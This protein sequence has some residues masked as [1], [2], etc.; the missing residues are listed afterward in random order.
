VNTVA[1]TTFTEQNRVVL[2]AAPD[3]PEVKV[4]D[5]AAMLAVYES[6]RTETLAAFVD[7]TSDAP[8]VP[9]LP[10]AGKIVSERRLP[11]TGILEWKLSNGARMLLKPTDFKED[12]VLFE[13]QSPGGVSLLDDRD[14][15]TAMGSSVLQSVSGL[16]TFNR[17]ALAKKLTGKKATAG[18]GIDATNEGVY[19]NASRK[20]IETMFQLVW[21]NFTAP[22]VDT[23]A[24]K[25]LTNQMKAMM[26]NQRN[27]PS[28]VFSDTITLTMAQHHPRVRIFVP[29]L[30]DSVD[31]GRALQIYKERFADA[32]DFTF[33]M[34]GSFAPDSV[35]PFVERYIASLPSRGKKESAMDR[36]VRPPAGVVTKVVHKGIEPKAS[37]RLY[38]SSP[39]AY[40]FEHRVVLDGLRDLLDIRLREVLREDKGG[41]YGVGVSTSCNHIPY[42]RA[43][44]QVSFGSAPERV[45]ELTNAVFAV[46]D[47]IKAGVVSDSNLTKIKEIALRAHETSLK[48]NESWLSAMADAD[49]DGRDQRD[50]LRTPELVKRITREQ[51]RDAARVYLRKEQYARFTLL[52]E[53]PAKTPAV[54]P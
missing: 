36:G 5:A 37:T 21:L 7:S 28:K 40:S 34:V 19:A 6:A 24:F 9:R 41:T 29:E 3:Q 12:E 8:L 15:T 17:I 48:E 13:A 18:A 27:Q 22:R 52:P 20:D 30:L 1:R 25:A 38:F 53:E 46:I 43:S 16:G 4:P 42:E 35:R 2:V 51:L 47:S 54:K 14:L 32:G 33:F 10:V 26:S 50:F 39:C 44:V 23:A 11:E 45:E 49:E 31:L